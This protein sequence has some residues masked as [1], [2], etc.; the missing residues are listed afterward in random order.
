MRLD[1]ESGAAIRTPIAS[2]LAA[3]LGRRSIRQRRGRGRVA[4]VA[5]AGTLAAPGSTAGVAGAGSP[6]AWRAEAVAS[7]S[8]SRNAT[9]AAD[10]AAGA[11]FEDRARRG[12]VAVDARRWPR[13][14]S[15]GPRR[16]GRHRRTGRARA[17][18]T[19]SR[20]SAGRRWWPRRCA[21]PGPRR[22]RHRHRG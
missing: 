10:G 16:P 15:T 14:R 5:A 11:A 8:W 1:R 6:R 12:A 21:R 13:C 18:T 19:R 20:P 4:A 9:T 2:G 7:S 17:T 22:R 3:G